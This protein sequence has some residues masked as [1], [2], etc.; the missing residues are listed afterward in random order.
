M[1]DPAAAFAAALLAEIER[2]ARE[3]GLT[4]SALARAAFPD[5]GDPVG[6]WRKI[7]KERQN[8][9]LADAWGLCRAV[10]ADLAGMVLKTEPTK[11]SH[12]KTDKPHRFSADNSI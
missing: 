10:E 1:T 8:L 2:R 7:R 6:R 4:H 11:T 12:S 9:S 3:Q 5:A